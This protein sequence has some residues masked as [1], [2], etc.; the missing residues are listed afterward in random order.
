MPSVATHPGTPAEQRKASG[1][2]PLQIPEDEWPE[3]LIALAPGAFKNGT[4]GAAT[5][6]CSY[7]SL[8]TLL[9]ASVMHVPE[10]GGP[11][12]NK[13]FK[14]HAP[15]IVY[16]TRCWKTLIVILLRLKVV[17]EKTG[18]GKIIVIF[19][20]CYEAATA[21]E[22]ARFAMGDADLFPIVV[23]A[24]KTDQQEGADHTSGAY[25]A[26]WARGHL[27]LVDNRVA[28]VRTQG[29][30]HVAA[31]APAMPGALA[32]HASASPVSGGNRSGACRAMRVGLC[33]P[34]TPPANPQHIT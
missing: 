24:A 21:E 17:V 32:P 13:T 25:S 4:G 33:H 26:I 22:K 9:L 34:N 18:W 30:A 29:S 10:V 19:Q 7:E 6:V 5:V 31:L 27:S 3:L 8:V 15:C 2:L 14:S 12:P 23:G 20:E 16:I 11:A 1:P 28:Q